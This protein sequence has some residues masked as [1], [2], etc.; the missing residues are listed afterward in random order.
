MAFLCTIILALTILSA[1]GTQ[2]VST[3]TAEPENTDYPDEEYYDLDEEGVEPQLWE[4]ETE[5][6]EPPTTNYTVYHESGSDLTVG[7][8]EGL[9]WTDLIDETYN[10]YMAVIDEDG[11][12]LYKT[13][14]GL[15]CN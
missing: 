13:D 10:S 4:D 3:V 6:T 2:P 8:Y 14:R 9:C 5:E 7:Y 1:C 15:H 12:I 11:Q